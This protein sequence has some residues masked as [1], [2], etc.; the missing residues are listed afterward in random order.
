MRDSLKIIRILNPRRLYLVDPWAPGIDKNS[1]SEFYG[2]SL[3][4][5][6]TVY[7]SNS[8]LELI[9][10]EFKKQIKGDKVRL[11]Q[12]YSYNAVERFEDD[13]F[14]LIYIDATHVYESAI[15]DLNDYYPKLKKTGLM[16]GHD[17][18]KSD[19]FTVD[20]AVDE[21]RK[22]HK[23]TFLAQGNT[24]NSIAGA[25]SDWALWNENKMIESGYAEDL[26]R[27]HI[28]NLEKKDKQIKE[29]IEKQHR[30]IEKIKR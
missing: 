23:L 17:Y 8:D 28:K 4:G 22:I 7:S 10:Q 1:P 26:I 13:Y 16:C 19:H 9:K 21:F 6:K 27:R 25:Q 14:D 3:K 11:I 20:K 18:I 30:I 12:E 29:S 5:Q 15:A 24:V 2:G